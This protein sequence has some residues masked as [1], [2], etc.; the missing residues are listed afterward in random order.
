MSGL[1]IKVETQ[2]IMEMTKRK[3]ETP[4]IEKSWQFVK[5]GF[6]MLGVR[7]SSEIRWNDMVIWKEIIK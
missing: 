5:E 4:R 3:P 6:F 1:I 7:I 2:F